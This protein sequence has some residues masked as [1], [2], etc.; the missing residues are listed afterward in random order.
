VAARIGGM[1]FLV[2]CR[3]DA[4]AYYVCRQSPAL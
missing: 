4:T 2:F 3:D 1:S